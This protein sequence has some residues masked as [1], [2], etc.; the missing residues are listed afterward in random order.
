MAARPVD[1]CT[2][3]ALLV[4]ADLWDEVGGLDELLFPAGYVDADLAMAAWATGHAVR[5]EPSAVVHHRHAGTMPEGFKAW[6]HH[7]NRE[8]FRKR[9]ATELEAHEPRPDEEADLEAA[10]ERAL[11]RAAARAEAIRTGARA[12]QAVPSATREAPIADDLGPRLAR[13]ELRLRRDYIA[14][15]DPELERVHQEYAQEREV[16]LR[17]EA[18]LARARAEID[19]IQTGRWWRLRGRVLRLLSLARRMSARVSRSPRDRA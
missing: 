10:C 7:R 16:R 8:R 18:E 5:Y 15:A 11:A 12:A 13:L 6:V 9:W 2:S 14:I 19:A 17:T 1:Y 4:R 3:A